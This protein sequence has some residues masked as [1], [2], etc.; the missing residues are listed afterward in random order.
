MASRQKWEY[1]YIEMQLSGVR[2]TWSG[3]IT[4]D[5][6]AE[7][8]KMGRD[9]WEMTASVFLGAPFVAFYFKRPLG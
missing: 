4:Y 8:D 2:V 5:F 3:T 6:Q 9:G 1:T 7:I